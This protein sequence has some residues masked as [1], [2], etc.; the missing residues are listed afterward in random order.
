MIICLLTIKFIFLA[1]IVF[2]NLGQSVER[3]E[4]IDS[5][6]EHTTNYPQQIHITTIAV[7]W[8][9]GGGGEGWVVLFLFFLLLFCFGLFF[10]GFIYAVWARNVYKYGKNAPGNK[11]K[12]CHNRYKES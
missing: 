9:Y 3:K 2:H 7:S 5:E 4:K 12:I 11:P 6:C 1:K 10:G 8:G